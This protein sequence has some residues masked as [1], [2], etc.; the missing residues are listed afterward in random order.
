VQRANLMAHL[1]HVL[2]FRSHVSH[3]CVCLHLICHLRAV[4]GIMLAVPMLL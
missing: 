2:Q 4:S 3:R 1:V